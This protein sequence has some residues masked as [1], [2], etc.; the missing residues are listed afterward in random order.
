M[1]KLTKMVLIATTAIGLVIIGLKLSNI[2]KEYLFKQQ[3][4]H[5]LQTQGG[6]EITL[7]IDIK[8]IPVDQREQ[9]FKAS[10]DIIFKRFRLLGF[11]PFIKR[12]SDYKLV[13]QVAHVGNLN[14]LAELIGTTAQLSFWE[15][16]IK[17]ASPSSLPI[18]ISSALKHPYK[19]DL[20]GNDLKEATVMFNSDGK[21]QVQLN[22]LPTGAKKLTV[23]TIQNV[24]KVLAIVL[25]NNMIEAPRISE[26]ITT[27]EAV[28][29]GSFTIEQAKALQIQL[30]AGALPTAIEVIGKH[31]LSGRTKS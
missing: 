15:D 27:G 21:P 20:T 23:I 19:T 28:I 1:N 6:A 11:Y 4:L 29:S 10:Q 12:N 14:T 26:P 22:F 13:V 3:E 16:S 5:S 2:T 24:G 7:Q 17:K 9:I 25:D 18:G 30:N 31:L 8:N